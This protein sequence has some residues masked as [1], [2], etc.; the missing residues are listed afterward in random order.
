VEIIYFI[1]FFKKK[2][3]EKKKGDVE[4]NFIIIN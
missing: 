3:K 2:K 1:S 4:D